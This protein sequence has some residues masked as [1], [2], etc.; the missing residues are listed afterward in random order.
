MIFLVS[1]VDSCRIRGTYIRGR[2]SLC[3]DQTKSFRGLQDL[4]GILL[5]FCEA[6]RRFLSSVLVIHAHVPYCTRQTQC[7]SSS[8]LKKHFRGIA[9]RIGYVRRTLAARNPRLD[10]NVSEDEAFGSIYQKQLTM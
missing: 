7:R 8:P 3:Q 9:L 5:L 6:W 4:N 10:G 1:L 2:I